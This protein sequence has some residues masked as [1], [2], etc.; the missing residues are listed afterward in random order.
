VFETIASDGRRHAHRIYLS[1]TGAKADLGLD[2]HGKERDPKKSARLA[3]G[4][5]STI[6]CCVVWGNANVAHAMLA[7]GLETTAAVAYSFKEEITTGQLT[8]CPRSL[9]PASRPS[10]R[11][12][13]LS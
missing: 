11:G 7:E 8:L 9:P 10:R 3:E 2:G 1:P 13:R 4:Q 5:P 12:Q 6:R